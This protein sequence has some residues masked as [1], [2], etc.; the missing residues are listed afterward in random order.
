MPQR[1]SGPHDVPLTGISKS[2]MR[3]N[4]GEICIGLRADFGQRCGA[5]SINEV[6]NSARGRVGSIVPAGKRAYKSR[7]TQ[8]GF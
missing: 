3:P 2:N 8:G 1:D 7:I 5:P 6:A 4:S